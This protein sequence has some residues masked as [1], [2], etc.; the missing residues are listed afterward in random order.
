MENIVGV[1]AIGFTYSIF[2]SFVQKVEKNVPLGRHK[3]VNWNA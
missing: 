2:A 3:K 1:N